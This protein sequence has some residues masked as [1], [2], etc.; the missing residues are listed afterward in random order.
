[1]ISGLKRNH[2]VHVLISQIG[3]ASSAVEYVSWLSG[4][5]FMILSIITVFLAFQFQSNVSES[6]KIIFKL[7][8]KILR[9]TEA[10]EIVTLL[11]DFKYYATPSSIFE[12]SSSVSRV[13]L[14]FLIGIW[15]ICGIS[16]AIQDG[17]NTDTGVVWLG[18]ILDV[19]ITGLFVYLSLKLLQIIDNIDVI[20]EKK[21]KNQSSIIDVMNVPSLV[22]EGIPIDGVMTVSNIQWM[23]QFRAERPTTKIRVSREIAFDGYFAVLGLRSPQAHVY[24]GMSIENINESAG[25]AIQLAIGPS[26]QDELNKLF[27][28]KDAIARYETSLG[29]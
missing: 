21:T 22:N 27:L 14:K 24:M 19:S 13:L 29:F 26:D 15:V 28:R 16:R 23:L 18:W 5:M 4:F 1:L 8:E 10:A 17:Y 11:E 20:D 3:G 12:Q 6:K 25:E 2:I 7:R 9:R